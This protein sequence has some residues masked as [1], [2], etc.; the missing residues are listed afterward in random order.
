MKLSSYERLYL[1]A[2]FAAAASIAWIAFPA[3][4][5]R[6][7]EQPA[8]FDH[9]VHSDPDLGLDCSTCHPFTEDGRFGG[10]PST[11]ACSPCHEEYSTN[12]SSG[13]IWYPYARLPD[14]AW[15]P[16]ARH[17]R[18]AGLPCERCHGDHSSTRTLP[19]VEINRISGYSKAIW[20]T[21]I[22]GFSGAISLKMDYC[23]NCHEVS[24]ATI[25]CQD[26]HR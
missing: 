25:A 26:C 13:I 17:V 9:V 23:E 4:L 7:V 8:N 1:V 15:F 19:N 5:Y 24:G 11:E 3:V 18:L 10:I 22:S 6:S 14:N 2:G 21:D 16:H 12:S 20:G